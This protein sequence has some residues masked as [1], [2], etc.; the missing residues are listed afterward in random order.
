[1][2]ARSA[3]RTDLNL[4]VRHEISRYQIPN[5]QIQQSAGQRVDGDNFETMGIISYQH[6][7]SPDMV[8]NLR[9]MVRDNSNDLSSNPLSD[10]GNRLSAQRL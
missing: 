1:M 10:A 7:F 8:G 3:P 2:N 9:G 6:L 4:S 5:E